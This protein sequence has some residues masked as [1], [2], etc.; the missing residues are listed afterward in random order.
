MS[1]VLT[2]MSLRAVRIAPDQARAFAVARLDYDLVDGPLAQ[3]ESMDRRIID[4]LLEKLVDN[5]VAEAE[6]A[7]RTRGYEAGYRDGRDRM[8][9]EIREELDRETAALREELRQAH[10]REAMLREAEHRTLEQSIQQAVT[11]LRNAIAQVEATVV[12]RYEEIGRDLAT[13]VLTLVEDLLGRELATDGA[14]VV[15]AITRALGEIPGRTELTIAMHPADHELLEQFGVDLL[16][17]LGRPVTVLPDETVDRHGVIVTSGC[18]EVDAQIRAS[19][20]RLREALL[21]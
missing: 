19:L 21:R 5:A 11:T 9:A 7:A 3:R 4:P 18:T 8:V 1:G 6:S 15:G 14:H 10:E 16:N 2:T 17:G 13:V 12:P 20:D